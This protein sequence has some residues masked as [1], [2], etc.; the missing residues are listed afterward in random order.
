MADINDTRAPREDL[1]V[2]DGEL[3]WPYAFTNPDD[4]TE[5]DLTGC[6]LSGWAV[7]S[8]S[9]TDPVAEFTFLQSDDTHGKGSV[10][11]DLD[12]GTYFYFFQILA[13]GETTPTTWCWGALYISAKPG[14]P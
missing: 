8:L 12:P 7:K 5:A 9:D 6:T 4:G 11:L 14:E 3:N 13:A 10:S 2:F 1:R